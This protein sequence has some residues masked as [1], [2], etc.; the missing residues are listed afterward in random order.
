MPDPTSD[1]QQP[2]SPGLQADIDS[3][4]NPSKAAAAQAQKVQDTQ[5]AAREA[6]AAQG[7]KAATTGQGQVP[8]PLYDQIAMHM[9]RDTEIDPD[10]PNKYLDACNGRIKAM[11]KLAG[12]S[13]KIGN[14]GAANTY[15]QVASVL[16]A[17]LNTMHDKYATHLQQIAAQA[18]S[19]QNAQVDAQNKALGK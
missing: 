8:P 10:H 3:M 13:K 6:N 12:D 4:S 1:V 16:Q 2:N 18:I 19:E 5:K 15:T 9:M 7:L 14:M 11:L 17:H